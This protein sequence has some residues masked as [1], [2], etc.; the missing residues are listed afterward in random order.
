MTKKEF[1]EQKKF[2]V[3]WNK[4]DFCNKTLIKTYVM[5]VHSFWVMCKKCFIGE[6]NDI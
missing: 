5:V 6:D 3:S 2:Y 1:F 4:C